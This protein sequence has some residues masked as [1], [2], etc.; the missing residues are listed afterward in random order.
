[1]LAGN[2]GRHIGGLFWKKVGP[3]KRKNLSQRHH[4]QRSSFRPDP[5]FR[6]FRNTYSYDN[7]PYYWY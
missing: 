3:P 1:V 2:L 6:R 7:L 5:A 4:S